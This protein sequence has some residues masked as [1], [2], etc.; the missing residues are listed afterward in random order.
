[1]FSFCFDRESGFLTDDDFRKDF[2]TRLCEQDLV[3]CENQPDCTVLG[4]IQSL[5]VERIED[6][7][8]LVGCADGQ[9][10][11]YDQDAFVTEHGK[12]PLAVVARGDGVSMH[13]KGVSVAD[14]FCSDTGMFNVGSF[15]GSVGVWDT[16]LMEC[17]HLYHVSSCVNVIASG[18]FAESSSLI[19]VG[20][21]SDQLRLLDIRQE[22]N[23]HTLNGHSE[24]V[25]CLAWSNLS[26]HVLVS[27]DVV[28]TVFV[29]DVRKPVPIA[30]LGS[31]TP[32]QVGP[33]VVWGFGCLF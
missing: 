26:E 19:A 1:M 8:I 13:S 7:Y 11:I 30:S 9:L 3:L 24:E 31:K 5:R 18:V 2:V 6:R 27:G 21:K 14:W 16:N 15:D 29:W 22:A 17:A 23:A 25:T 28:G 10:A 4:A 12:K 32:P 33:S 20:T